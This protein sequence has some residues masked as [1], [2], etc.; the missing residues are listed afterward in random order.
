MGLLPWEKTTTCPYNPA[1]QITVSRIQK[2]LVKCR[3]N[4]KDSEHII[5][6][7]NASHHIPKAEE[8]YHVAHCSD[9]KIVELANYSWALEKPGLHG[10]LEI[11]PSKPQKFDS[12]LFLGEEEEDWER[13]LSGAV[14]KSYDPQIKCQKSNVLRKLPGAT[15]SERKKF[16]AAERKRHEEL[17]SVEDNTK[18]DDSEEEEEGGFHS[19]RPSLFSQ[20]PLVRPSTLKR[21]T[22]EKVE[23]GVEMG[24]EM[25]PRPG[26]ITSRLL[27][28]LPVN[29]RLGRNSN[30]QSVVANTIRES[31]A[32]EISLNN[33]LDSTLGRLALS[34]RGDRKG[35]SVVGTGPLRK[36][37]L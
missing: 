2:H 31:V 32:E 15:P 6:P 29:Q 33:T 12:N 19:P 9:R 7:Y 1:H 25:I 16:Y 5:C 34:G 13:D 21:P 10:N 26:S 36:P 4:N 27:H 3:R 18:E 23:K 28:L 20:E 17:K 24:A 35:K 22:I 30:R 8:Q 37:N 11:P 14:L